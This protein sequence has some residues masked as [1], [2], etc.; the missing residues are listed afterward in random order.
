MRFAV[1][2]ASLQLL[3]ALHGRAQ[4]HTI[5]ITVATL[6]ATSSGHFGAGA[7]RAWTAMRGEAQIALNAA[8][9]AATVT[10][11]LQLNL[12][13][14]R[15]QPFTIGEPAACRGVRL[16]ASPPFLEAHLGTHAIQIRDAVQAHLNA[17]LTYD[18][19]SR[20]FRLSGSSD[21]AKIAVRIRTYTA[22]IV[23]DV[24]ALDAT[25]LDGPTGAPLE[26]EA[27]K[28]ACAEFIRDAA[29]PM[30]DLLESAGAVERNAEARLQ[31]ALTAIDRIRDGSTGAARDADALERAARACEKEKYL[32]ALERFRTADTKAR[33]DWDAARAARDQATV[34]VHNAHSAINEYDMQKRARQVLAFPNGDAPW[35]A[36]NQRV[37]SL[38]QRLARMDDSPLDTVLSAA[39]ARADQSV[40]TFAACPKP[41]AGGPPVRK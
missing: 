34:K 38:Q 27:R 15:E 8:T 3:L 21:P 16:V 11:P 4:F 2:C 41:D 40:E 19:R 28:A 25:D 9:G 35:L 33:A 1:R 29:N 14:D 5:P 24:A 23:R 26:A 7:R 30:L 31:E 22:S 13:Q 20:L 10:I 36:A 6:P 17:A 32:P 39:E 18:S 37:T 12:N